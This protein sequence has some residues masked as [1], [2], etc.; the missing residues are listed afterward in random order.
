MPH[1]SLYMTCEGAGENKRVEREW[2]TCHVRPGN[3]S[4]E[5]RE[6]MKVKKLSSVREGG[7]E[8]CR[9]F[10]GEAEESW[11]L[12]VRLKPLKKQTKSSCKPIPRLALFL[13]RFTGSSTI[14][15]GV[16]SSDGTEIRA[17]PGEWKALDFSTQD[18]QNTCRTTLKGGY[19]LFSGWKQR[20]TQWI[21][22]LIVMRSGSKW[23]RG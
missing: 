11:L 14:G 20:Y 2:T 21:K 3:Q 10:R 4:T 7:M 15:K 17:T 5:A 16:T 1:F 18:L 9:N 23:T 22:C 8:Q 12:E 6:I 13:I 19:M